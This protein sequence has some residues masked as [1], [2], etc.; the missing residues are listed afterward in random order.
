MVKWKNRTVA[1]IVLLGVA[2]TLGA[3]ASASQG[4]AFHGNLCASSDGQKNY[5]GS[6]FDIQSADKVIYC[7]IDHIDA[8]NNAV[9]Q[10]VTINVNDG[11]TTGEVS[12]KVYTCWAN[13]STCSVGSPVATGVSDTGRESLLLGNKTTYYYGTAAIQCTL[14]NSSGQINHK[15][16]SYSFI[17]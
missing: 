1:G 5:Y 17:E 13:G 2:S 9:M 3:S 14:S 16:Y 11:S 8:G 6:D 12:C 7:P 4:Y 15:I 10:N